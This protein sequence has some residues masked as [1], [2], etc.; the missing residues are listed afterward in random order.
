VTAGGRF[1]SAGGGGTIGP[2]RGGRAIRETTSAALALCALAALAGRADEAE[3]PAS[4][5]AELKKLKG[6]W[7]VTKWLAKGDEFEARAGMTYTFDGN[8]LTR[9]WPVTGRGGRADVQGEA[10]H[11]EGAAQ[12]H[13]DARRQGKAHSGAYKF[14]K[15]LLHLAT[16]RGG[17]ATDFDGRGVQVLVMKREKPE[18]K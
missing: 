12:D 4:A 5:K 13:D 18:E 16:A 2:H 14:E 11:Q 17:D 9:V 6:T 7:T 15:G 10:R 1:P 3:P 8:R